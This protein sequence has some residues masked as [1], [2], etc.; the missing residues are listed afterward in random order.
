MSKVVLSAVLFAA[1]QFA[2][3]TP[4][5]VTKAT[6]APGSGYGTEWPWDEIGGGEKLDVVFSNAGF[7]TQHF[8]LSTVGST[9]SFKVGTVKFLENDYLSWSWSDWSWKTYGIDSG[10]TDKLNVSLA[11]TFTNPTAVD[12]TFLTTGTAVLGRVGDSDVDYT[13]NWSPLIVNFG[14]GGEYTISLN[15]L[16][17]NGAS[18]IPKDL[19]ATVTLTR[20]VPEPGSLA[21][22]GLGLAG[23]G[24]MRRRRVS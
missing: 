22:I 20:A 11:L 3:A 18:T 7:M 5:T 1:T 19:N 2:S 12:N 4:F 24:F 8:N 17:F 14:N 13:L 6:F 21:L 15:S 16:S 23:A 10:E 9:A